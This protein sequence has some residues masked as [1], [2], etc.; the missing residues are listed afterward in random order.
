MTSEFVLL[1]V[2]KGHE[3]SLFNYSKSLEGGNTEVGKEFQNIPE[4]EMNN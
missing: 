3:T 2:K 4:K 1:M